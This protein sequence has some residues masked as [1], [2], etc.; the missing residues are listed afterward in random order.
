MT[1]KPIAVGMVA[2]CGLA[3]WAVLPSCSSTGNSVG[4]AFELEEATILELQDAMETGEV[5]S[6]D[7]VMMYLGRIDAYDQKGPSINA[8]I[9]VNPKAMEEAM[10][11]D[12][13]RETS[14]PRGP[15]HGVPVVV[16]DNYDTFDMPTTNGSRSLEGMIPPDGTVP[17]PWRG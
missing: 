14:G 9:H 7:L 13:E 15:L 5:S 8:M 6:V 3:P 4:H 10:A 2:L 1:P 16:K 11:L 17:V 12:R